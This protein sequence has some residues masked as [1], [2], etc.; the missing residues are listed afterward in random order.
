[1]N[2]SRYWICLGLATGIWGSS[3]AQELTSPDLT[4]LSLTDLLNVEVTTVSRAA[5]PLSQAPA[6]IT[7]IKGE[8]IRRTGATTIPDALRLA[9][10]LQVAQVDAH[11]WAISARGFNDVFANKLL[12]M[13]DGR[14]VYSPLFSGVFWD[15]QDTLLEDIDRIEVIRGPGAAL[16]GANAVNGVINI[17]TKDARDTHGVLLSAGTGT[18][19]LGF[20]HVRY[21]A[22]L[23]ENAS[24]RVYAKYF[25]RDNA[26]LLDGSA[27]NDHW[28]MFRGGFRLDWQPGDPNLLTF[29][30][31]A[32]VGTLDQ[33]YNVPTFTPPFTALLADDIEAHG[34]NILGRW[35]H[36]FS[37]DSEMIW[38]LYFDQSVRNTPVFQEERVTADL[39]FQHHFILG[40]RQRITWGGGYHRTDDEAGN[41]LSVALIP[42]ERGLNL[43]SAFI[44]DEIQIIHDK[45]ALTLGSK[46]EH[47]DFT[48]FEIQPN[49][50][51]AW[52]PLTNAVLWGAVSRAVRTPSRA[53]H[54]IIINPPG[55][56]PG[57]ASL[58]GNRNF[59]SEDLIAYEIGFRSQP[60]TRMTW[61]IATFYNDYDNLR[62]FRPLT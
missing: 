7:V 54:D 20:G 1:M 21:G 47:N 5:E 60:T 2:F 15:V 58:F 24:A 61:E 46:F 50:R 12:V 13:I 53:E 8:D 62:S 33:T 48:G 14:T 41:T 49:A 3:S 57:S 42:E 9:P 44:Q 51:I 38:Q 16:W 34:G 6:A 39:D 52:T 23:S 22:K 18:E 29:Q 26:R 17:I 10:G 59:D 45:L 19:E 11:T 56:P 32:Y 40:E 28:E 35:T 55:A 4:E 30:G 27:A 25:N 37:S 31:D 36:T 43:Y